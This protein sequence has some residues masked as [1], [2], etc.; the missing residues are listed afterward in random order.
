MELPE[1]FDYRGIF[2]EAHRRLTAAADEAAM[3]LAIARRTGVSA[4]DKEEASLLAETQS[5]TDAVRQFTQLSQ[6]K[7]SLAQAEPSKAAATLAKAAPSARATL[8]LPG[9]AA[10]SAQPMRNIEFIVAHVGDSGWSRG[11][12]V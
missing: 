8:R 3:E 5:L 12:V 1:G 10:P 7:Q 11:K 9:R 4:A 2:A 6:A